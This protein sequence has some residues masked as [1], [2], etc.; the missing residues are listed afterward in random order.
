MKQVATSLACAL[1]VPLGFWF[2]GFD[3]DHRGMGALFCYF[4]CGFVFGAVFFY[5]GWD[6][7]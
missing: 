5:P 4:L 3:F 7:K 2:G 1:L 6:D